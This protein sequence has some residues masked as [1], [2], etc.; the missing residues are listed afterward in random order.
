[1]GL[2]GTRWDGM[3]PDGTGWDGRGTGWVR[4][5][6]QW[7][8]VKTSESSHPVAVCA[9]PLR[10]QQEVTRNAGILDELVPQVID[11]F[12]VF[13]KKQLNVNGVAASARTDGVMHERAFG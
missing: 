13:G 9:V 2:G 5:G 10:R 1:M 11:A 7:D 12:P 6:R 4:V 8:G 3:G